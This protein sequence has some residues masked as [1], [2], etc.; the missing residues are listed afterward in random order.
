MD[1]RRGR[2]YTESAGKTALE[3]KFS[4]RSK[5]TGS[6]P[7]LA[8]TKRKVNSKENLESGAEGA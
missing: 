2:G 7:A 4:G 8:E 6:Q 1:G 5:E 3:N